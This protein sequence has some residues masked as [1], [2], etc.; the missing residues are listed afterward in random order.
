M[1][2]VRLGV[3]CLVGLV[4]GC[5]SS[6]PQPPSVEI[7]DHPGGTGGTGPIDGGTPAT[8][9]DATTSEAGSAFVCSEPAAGECIVYTNVGADTLTELQTACTTNNGSEV[10]SCST[11]SLVG[12]CTQQLGYTQETCYYATAG[13]VSTTQSTA[14]TGQSGVFTALP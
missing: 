2:M 6:S 3:S 1:L 12:C 10:S 5:S 11:T 14:C 8:G 13:F 7:G 4:I 9:F